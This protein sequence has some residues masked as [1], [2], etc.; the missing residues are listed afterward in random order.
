MPTA[1]QIAKRMTYDP[2][3]EIGVNVRDMMAAHIAHEIKQERAA[4]QELAAR[5]G[6]RDAEEIAELI[7]Q[8]NFNK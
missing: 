6:G 8:R 1:E 2:V 5:Y 7:G 3:F 4:C